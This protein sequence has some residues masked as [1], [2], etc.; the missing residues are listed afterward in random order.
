MDKRKPHYRLDEIK[1]I[2]S[3]VDYLRMGTTALITMNELNFTAEDVVRVVQSLK[4]SDF[5][6]SMTSYRDHRIWQD[7]YHKRYQ[8]IVLY[9]KFTID[10]EGYLI[11]SLK[12]K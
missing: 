2:F 1:L 7:V 6:K 9:I 10:D 4:V 12:E 5:Y 11:L 8:N 3:A